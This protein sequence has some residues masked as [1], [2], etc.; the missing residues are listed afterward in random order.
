MAG[1]I[2][3]TEE[4]AHIRKSFENPI[5]PRTITPEGISTTGKTWQ[6]IQDEAEILSRAERA[7]KGLYRI[8]KA[9]QYVVPE[10]GASLALKAANVA[11]PLIKGA[12]VVGGVL[13]VASGI[14]DLLSGKEQ[15]SLSGMD[16]ISPMRLGMRA[17][18]IINTAINSSPLSQGQ[19]NAPVSTPSMAQPPAS[20]FQPPPAQGKTRDQF[21][22]EIKDTRVES[23]PTAPATSSTPAI[24]PETMYTP[25]RGMVR[26]E[27]TGE[28]TML[29]QKSAVSITTD[30]EGRTHIG[31]LG[32]AED[33]DM[34]KI[35]QEKLF[36]LVDS[37]M[38]GPSTRHDKLRAAEIL[39]GLNTAEKGLKQARITGEYGLEAGRIKAATDK[40]GHAIEKTKAE[41]MIEGNRLTIDANSFAKAEATRAREEIA[42]NNLRVRT[43]EDFT[44]TL[45][46]VGSV[47]DSESGKVSVN[48]ILGMH[49]L[50]QQGYPESAIPAHWKPVFKQAKSEFAKFMA[51]WVRDKNKGKP[52]TDADI[53]AMATVFQNRFRKTQ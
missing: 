26:N 50:D 52:A 24:P 5:P 41:A 16:Y 18:N 35:I 21:M 23:T 27:A 9:A 10:A 12:G 37:V 40:E 32:G 4:L 11:V 30:K 20:A 13:D 1:L 7:R 15:T 44:K 2:D 45:A 28:T 33:I 19:P 39:G 29:P 8:G 22:Q 42:A 38:K 34:Q 47:W 53:R 43:D 3:R 14:S 36:G 46:G 6:A 49:I 31:G 48:Q 17:G 51:D 25:P